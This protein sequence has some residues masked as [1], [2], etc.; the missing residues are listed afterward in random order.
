MAKK[1]LSKELLEALQDP[2]VLAQV[3][4]KKVDDDELS[5][6][7]APMQLDE[8][9]SV[10]DIQKE[11]NERSK[12]QMAYLQ[13]LS[14]KAKQEAQTIIDSQKEEEQDKL[15][16]A[17][18]S[19]RPW[20]NSNKAL[21]EEMQPL[22][23]KSGNLDDAYK[24]ACKLHDL[25]PTTGKKPEEKKAEKKEEK[26]QTQQ[27]SNELDEGNEDDS[28]NN[29]DGKAAKKLTIR[30]RAAEHS[31]RLAAEGKNPFRKEESKSSDED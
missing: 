3:G 23:E 9:A 24:K 19:E 6:I 4:L 22:Y 7:F 2:D 11:L 10:A 20:L 15:I 28:G 27:R 16:D 29:D 17:F 8:N 12:K 1:K 13:K 25:D 5:E 26:K 21:L 14:G 31:N 30:E 18:L